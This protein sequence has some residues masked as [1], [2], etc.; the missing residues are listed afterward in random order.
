[1]KAR[2]APWHLNKLIDIDGQIADESGFGVNRNSKFESLRVHLLH[3]SCSTTSKHSLLDDL[4]YFDGCGDY[5]SCLLV[6][7]L[8]FD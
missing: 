2:F 5:F 3:I 4:A 7:L 6:Y 8:L 1:L